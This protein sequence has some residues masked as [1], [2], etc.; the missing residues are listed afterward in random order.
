[1]KPLPGNSYAAMWCAVVYLSSL[2]NNFIKKL[3]TQILHRF[4]SWLCYVENFQWLEALTM[5]PGGSKTYIT[6]VGSI[7]CKTNNSK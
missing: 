1:M 3:S 4:I 7:F 6:V 5:V 2:L